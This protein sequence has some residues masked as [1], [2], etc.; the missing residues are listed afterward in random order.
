MTRDERQ[1]HYDAARRNPG[2]VQM[3]PDATEAD[4]I[5]A[6]EAVKRAELMLRG[7]PGTLLG[8]RRTA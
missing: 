5:A 8:L 6:T 3:D 4:V 2:D 1:A 7:V